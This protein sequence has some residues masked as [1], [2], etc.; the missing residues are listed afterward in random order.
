MKIVIMMLERD[1][2]EEVWKE[3]GEHSDVDVEVVSD[4]EDSENDNHEEEE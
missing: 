1:V 2:S 4:D 3:N